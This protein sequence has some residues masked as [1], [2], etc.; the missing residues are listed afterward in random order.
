MAAAFSASGALA[1]YFWDSPLWSRGLIVL[2]IPVILAASGFVAED[3]RAALR[4]RLA[5]SA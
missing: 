4:R 5:R 3:E 2:T 1:W